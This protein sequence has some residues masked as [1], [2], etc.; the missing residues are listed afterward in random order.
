MYIC[1]PVVLI[2]NALL[3]VL[4][5]NIINNVFKMVDAFV[6]W[7]NIIKCFGS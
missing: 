7:T 1:L 3:I 5:R 6:E 4:T 2:K